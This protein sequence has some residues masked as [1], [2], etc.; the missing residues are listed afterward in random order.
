M[1]RN[2]LLLTIVTFVFFPRCVMADIITPLS[3]YTIPLIPLIILIEACVLWVWATKF[4]KVHVGFWKS[5][6]VTSV[7]NM[8]TSLLGTFIPL[9]KHFGEN[10]MWIGV[11]F[12]FSVLIEWRIYLP[13]FRRV[14]IGTSDL[15]KVALIGNFITYA[16]LVLAFL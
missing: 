3:L 8:A 6:L 13:F 7:A 11:A 1:N 16:I 5:I 2:P 4:V 12:A 10:L 14:N 9:Y 15:L